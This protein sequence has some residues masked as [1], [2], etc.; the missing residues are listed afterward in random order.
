MNVNIVTRLILAAKALADLLSCNEAMF[1]MRLMRFL[2]LSAA[3][4]QRRS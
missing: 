4:L 1:M 2:V 3:S